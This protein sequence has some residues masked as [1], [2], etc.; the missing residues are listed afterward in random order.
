MTESPWA[1]DACTLPTVERPARS[2]E[3]DELFATSVRPVEKL[4]PTHA[5]LH[6]T[7]DAAGVRDLAAREAACCS[8]FTFT[9]GAGTLDIEVPVR[10]AD[11]LA[12]LVAKAA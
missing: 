5:R 8:F 2:A 10:Y 12:A 9:V 3:F 7:G 1:P 6:F 11:V 4:S